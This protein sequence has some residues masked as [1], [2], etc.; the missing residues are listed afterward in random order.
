MYYSSLNYFMLND[1]CL[2]IVID[3][4]ISGWIKTTFISSGN[5]TECIENDMKR[6]WNILCQSTN[7]AIID[8]HFLCITKRNVERCLKFESS[9]SAIILLYL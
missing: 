4:G 3:D 9:I 6:K 5:I 1:L 2:N 8:F 7:L